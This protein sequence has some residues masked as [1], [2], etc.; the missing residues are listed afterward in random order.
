MLSKMEELAVEWAISELKN[1]PDN[2]K[3]ETHWIKH[4]NGSKIWTANGFSHIDLITKSF[5]IK[6]EDY[7]LTYDQKYKTAAERSNIWTRIGVLPEPVKDWR[8]RLWDAYIDWK[9]RSRDAD[10]LSWVKEL[11]QDK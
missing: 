11:D 9:Q 5:E 4:K 1:A 3:S 2:W 6:S 8:E 7:D 10:I